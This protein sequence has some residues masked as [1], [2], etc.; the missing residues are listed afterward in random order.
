MQSYRCTY[1]GNVDSVGDALASFKAFGGK[2]VRATRCTRG[3][4]YPRAVYNCPNCG[5]EISVE[6]GEGGIC[7]YCGGK[8]VRSEFTDAANM[9]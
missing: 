4:Q 5:A 1:C 6:E 9:L 8:L 3:T 7:D 2:L